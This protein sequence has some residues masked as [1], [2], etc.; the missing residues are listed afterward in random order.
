LISVLMRDMRFLL[1][2]EGRWF[3]SFTAARNV[4]YVR[5]QNVSN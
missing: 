1:M 5:S 2:I 4:S 3:K